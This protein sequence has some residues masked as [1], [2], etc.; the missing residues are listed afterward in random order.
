MSG[1]KRLVLDEEDLDVG[2]LCADWETWGW[3]K[4]CLAFS[5]PVFSCVQW[6]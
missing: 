6:K 2:R 4:R 1:R 3:A 5:K